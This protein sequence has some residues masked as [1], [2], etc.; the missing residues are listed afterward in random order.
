VTARPTQVLV[1]TGGVLCD[2]TN[3]SSTGAGYKPTGS[4]HLKLEQPSAVPVA[5]VVGDAH[6]E[7]AEG[8]PGN[9][10]NPQYVVEYARDIYSMLER[11]ESSY[12]PRPDY[13]EAQPDIN[14]KMRAILVDWLVEVHMKYKLKTETLFLAVNLIDRFL[15]RR[16]ITRK[17]LQLV[18]VTGML[19]AAKFEEIY[20]PEV[21]DFVYITDKAYA[22]EE[23]LQME[24]AMLTE[25][26]FTLCCPTVAHFFNRYQ[27]LNQCSEAHRHLLQYVLELTLPEFKMIRYSPSTLAAA[28]TLLSNK[29]TKHSPAWPPAMIRHTKHTETSVKSCAKEMCGLIEG[30]ERNPL[31]AVRKKFSQPKY[32]A[33]A[34]QTF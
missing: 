8:E 11:D 20:P 16:K 5:G 2:I 14:S 7:D 1:R 15:E 23:I 19:I 12:L 4:K 9:K 34:K 29:L 24:V 13:L 28:A 25:L 32:S 30:A 22:K 10:D 26:E 18:G 21:R 31:Q 27:Q 3:V 17:K 33:V 6:G